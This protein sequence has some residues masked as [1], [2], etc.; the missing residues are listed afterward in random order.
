MES[1][2]YDAARIHM[3]LLKVR[4]AFLSTHILE[5]DEEEEIESSLNELIRYFYFY[6][7]VG[8]LGHIITIAGP[9]GVGKSTLVNNIL[10]LNEEESLPTEEGR[11]ETLPVVLLP[12]NTQSREE[13]VIYR[14][15]ES[16]E[17]G[18]QHVEHLSYSDARDRITLTRN[19]D[20][21][22]AFWYVGGSKL[23]QRISP[24]VVLPGLELDSLWAPDIKAFI[25]L[26]DV[27]MLVTDSSRSAQNS[28]KVIED[29]IKEAEPPVKPIIVGTFAD[30]MNDEELQSFKGFL[31]NAD[32]PVFDVIMCGID[33]CEGKTSEYEYSKLYDILIKALIH[34]PIDIKARNFRKYMRRTHRIVKRIENGLSQ[35]QMIKN[36]SKQFLVDDYMKRVDEYLKKIKDDIMSQI[37]KILTQYESISI[38]RGREVREKEFKGFQKLSI[39][40]G[41][42][43][44][45]KVIRIENAIKDV[46]LSEE[47]LYEIDNTL[48]DSLYKKL[49]QEFREVED[50]N[51]MSDRV[52]AEIM[53][54]EDFYPVIL[55]TLIAEPQD[56]ID[57][58]ELLISELQK[59]ED[60][61]QHA[62]QHIKNN[63]ER[64]KKILESMKKAKTH[65]PR[66][67]KKFTK[68]TLS[69]L[70]ETVT[71]KLPKEQ[72]K[73]S[74]NIMLAS[75]GALEV[76]ME[77]VGAGLPGAVLTTIGAIIGVAFAA[78]GL[79]GFTTSVIATGRAAEWEIDV[80]LRRY[81]EAA[82]EEIEEQIRLNLE[83]FLNRWA[84]YTRKLLLSSIG[85]DRNI[86]VLETLKNV[87]LLRQ[88]LTEIEK[89]LW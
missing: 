22:V 69:Q 39:A 40:L 66:K 47:L 16:G 57:T 81:A 46:F 3:G 78:A 38:Q 63:L 75:A 19:E 64:G 58:Q 55:T 30:T 44:V 86:Y 15:S 17:W 67:V 83:R 12:R 37:G 33:G 77:A 49:P 88:T 5:P 20:D 2:V 21:L 10:G 71:T 18:T 45:N 73:V 23:L 1:L 56:L 87:N 35:E 11:G 36:L 76:F 60:I 68:K 24:L 6:S 70:A 54:I 4:N 85:N 79:V 32:L 82:R 27:I 42:V 9:Q 14:K 59:N 34:V 74:A 80:Y 28:A 84:V 61:S 62:F 13:V 43:S 52:G 29:W 7:T 25:N 41:G 53:Q 26:S 50:N 31:K 72:A 48:R 65:S 89:K 51:I 8:Q